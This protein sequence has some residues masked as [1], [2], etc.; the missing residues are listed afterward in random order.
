M[1]GALP[2]DDRAID[3]GQFPQF[4]PTPPRATDQLGVEEARAKERR[5]RGTAGQTV[6]S[7]P[8]VRNGGEI[9]RLRRDRGDSQ[10]AANA[11]VDNDIAELRRLRDTTEA[12]TLAEIERR[13]RIEAEGGKTP[14]D[15]CADL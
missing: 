3:T 2:A 9:A 10:A 7:T 11:P 1:D 14:S 15:I 5:L 4:S 8:P 6:R 12:Q 13:C